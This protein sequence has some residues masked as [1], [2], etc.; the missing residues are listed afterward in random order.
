MTASPSAAKR[1][2]VSDYVLYDP[3]RSRSIDN[4]WKEFASP[5]P[6]QNYSDVLI[7]DLNE[8]VYP[9]LIAATVA[10]GLEVYSRTGFDTWQSETS[11]ITSDQYISM[12]K[13][14]F[15]GDNHDDLL[16]C[17]ITV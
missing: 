5:A 10:S 1:P 4:P 9:D 11:P 13:G 16:V 7:F 3:W 14:D 6:T 2:A 12:D 17:E 8:D 15:N